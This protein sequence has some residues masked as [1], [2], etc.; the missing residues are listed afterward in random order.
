MKEVQLR[1]RVGIFLIIS[2]FCVILT[3][4]GLYLAGG[5]LFDEM[6]T[7]IALMMPFFASFTT[8][9]VKFVIKNK[10]QTRGKSKNISGMFAFIGFLLPCLFIAVILAAIV[11]KAL[12]VG[13]SSF[14]EFKTV[15]TIF[16]TVFA[17]YVGQVVFSLF[18]GQP[19]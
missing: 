16:E 17:V 19:E 11:L 8:V 9:I 2:H 4:I 3:V 15:V 18:K 13:F 12:N 10:Y 14:E 1:N 5:F 7:T 6:T